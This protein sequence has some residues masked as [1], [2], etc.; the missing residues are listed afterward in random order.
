MQAELDGHQEDDAEIAGVG[1]HRD[2]KG[3]D[4]REE[5]VKHS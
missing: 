1:N 5:L 2:D 3:H 4:R